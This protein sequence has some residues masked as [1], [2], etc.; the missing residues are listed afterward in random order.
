LLDTRSLLV[1][2]LLEPDR[3]VR[4]SGIG[5]TFG[6]DTR[7]NCNNKRSILEVIRTGETGN[8]CQYS[9]GDATRGEFL[10]LDY[11][12]SARFLGANTS[13]NRLTATYQRYL[14][15]NA[16]NKTVL[17]GRVNLGLASLFQARD[18]NGNGVIDETDKTMPISE[19]FFAGGSTTLRGFEFEEAGPRTVI[20]PQGTF[21]NNRGE[22]VNETGLLNPFTVPDGGNA[23]A[24]VNLEARIPLVSYFQ[25]V[26]FYDGGNVFRRVSEI[27]KPRKVAPGDIANANSRALWSNTVGV[28]I[29]LA[30][31]IGSSIAVDYGYLLNPPEFL[32]PQ[33]AAPPAIY[34][35]QQGQ[36]HFRFTQAF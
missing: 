5:A 26:P 12:L 30:T 3:F 15:I 34:R 16:L 7:E 25:V 21:R 23:L 19:R 1:A 18:R 14:Q 32:I 11:Q 2:P 8:P 27:F 4:V 35:L 17:A 22:L 36:I 20:I 6:R 9:A 13:Y 24:I 10:S 28:G 31:P 33:P 29:R